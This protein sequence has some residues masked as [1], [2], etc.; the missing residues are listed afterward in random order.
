MNLNGVEYYYVR[1]AQDDII[2]LI[3]DSGNLVVTYVYDSWGKL[4]SINGTLKDTVGVKNPY[5]YRGYRYDNETGLYYLQ[6]RYYNP[7]WGRVVNTDSIIGQFG[8]PLSHNLYAYCRNNPVN[9]SDPTG[10][11][12][13][14]TLLYPGEIHNAVVR[15]IKSV[16]GF[17]TE[18]WV[19]TGRADIINPNTREVWEVK[20]VTA[21]QNSA[22]EQ[23]KK[24]TKG[25]WNG[26]VGLNVGG[27]SIKYRNFNYKNYSVTYWYEGKGIIRYTF[28]IRNKVNWSYAVMAFVSIA[29]SIIAISA[30]GSQN[31][32]ALGLI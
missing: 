31:K 5:R 3:D 7:E 16:Y 14:D 28:K 30:N 25:T 4:V 18:Q 26:R 17:K 27:S 20:P 12:P 15:D 19:G 2:G 8:E 23:L 21:N 13:W 22:Y 1:N 6:S 24:Y 10:F 32:W 9:F 11:I 29:G